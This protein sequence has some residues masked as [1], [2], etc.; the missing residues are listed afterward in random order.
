MSF[1]NIQTAEQLKD[2]IH[3]IHDFIRNSGAGYGMS[4]L[5]IFNVFYSLRIIKGKCKSFNLD[6]NSFEW[7]KLIDDEYNPIEV[8][9]S[10]I[11]NLLREYSSKGT[12]ND[13]MRLKIENGRINTLYDEFEKYINPSQLELFKDK[14]DAINDD[15]EKYVKER[16]PTEETK[17]MAFY[18]YHQ[19]PIT[20]KSE[21]YREIYKLVDN[22]PMQTIN[23]KDIGDITNKFDIKGKVYE[24]FIGR[25][26]SAISEMG[27]YFTDRY[28]TNFTFEFIDLQLD[29]NGNVPSM[30]DPFGGSGG[31]TI[32]Y[33]KMLSD[34]FNI[35]WSK[36]DNYKQVYHYDMSEDVVK[37]AGVEYFTLT[38][39]FPIR[40]SQFK[41]TNTFTEDFT[42]KFRNVISNP[43]YGGDKNKSSVDKE[44]NT[45][46]IKTNKDIIGHIEATFKKLVS[47]EVM[48]K[49]KSTS[50][51]GYVYDYKKILIEINGLEKNSN[52]FDNTAIRLFKNFCSKYEIAIDNINLFKQC[53]FLDNKDNIELDID[54][55]DDF[56][57]VLATMYKQIT[58]LTKENNKEDITQTDKQV[59]LKTCSKFIA[60][61]AVE[62]VN[63]D[64]I[65]SRK[66]TIEE[67]NKEL[68]HNTGNKIKTDNLNRL[69]KSYKKE[70]IKYTL[71]NKFKETYF[72][73]KESCSLILLMNLLEENGTCVG[74][75]KEGVFFD[76]KYSILRGFIIHNYNIT[77]IISIP[78][79]AFENT[80][81][82]TSIIVFHKNGPTAKINFWILDVE[83]SQNVLITCNKSSGNQIK[84]LKE[85]IKSVNKKYLCSASLKQLCKIKTSYNKNN[86][87]SFELSYSLDFK[88][89]IAYT[90]CCPPGFADDTLNNHLKFKP[91][92]KRQA[93]FAD[94]NGQYTFYTSSDKIKKCTELDYKDDDLKLI[95]G[96]GGNG[97]LFIDTNFSCSGDN[98]VC[99]IDNKLMTQYV[100]FYIKNNWNEFIFRM[101]NGSTIGHIGVEKLKTFKIP[102]PQDINK[103]QPQLDTLYELHLRIS[104]MTQDIPDK[105]KHICGLIKRLTDEGKKG[106]DY[107]QDKLG[108]LCEINY[109]TR[110]TKNNNT[111]GEFPVYGG[112]DIAFYTNKYN[113][114]NITC[115]IGRFG[116]GQKCVRIING[117]FWL[118]D[119]GLSIKYIKN[120]NNIE[121]Y[122]WYYLMLY[123]DNIYNNMTT[124]SIQRA[125]NMDIFNKFDIKVLKPHI[126]AQHNMQQ[127][128]DEV[129]GMKTQ[130]ETLKQS[131]KSAT[132]ELFK[133]FTEEHKI[134]I[135]CESA[136]DASQDIDTA[137][138]APDEEHVE[139]SSNASKKVAVKKTVARKKKQTIAIDDTEEQPETKVKVVA[140]R[141]KN[142]VK[143]KTMD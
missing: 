141:K 61:Y 93:S 83:K 2:Y 43:P 53:F 73:D 48:A 4:A 86:E 42:R 44:K 126:M 15:F 39:Y 69:L 50:K 67:I 19:I 41:C 45:I 26:K 65:T 12:D 134:T 54:N 114:D 1:N 25:D 82:K 95:F 71:T 9:V 20:T 17:N 37:N 97:S 11:V 6:E 79:K 138:N 64:V 137:S 100:Y 30:I 21:F 92:S 119:N 99:N 10:R 94:E 8:K 139:T 28:I 121:K 70:P 27:A 90:V 36:N 96:T 29:E 59:N 49:M 85:Q 78:D 80:T 125:L 110:I 108:K 33:T 135:S 116:L 23:K 52:A 51:A 129:D 56:F 102:I 68:L 31:F 63:N 74:L 40:E 7:D 35:D 115:I 112:G 84:Y 128:F 5:K 127:L 46:I 124:V 18:I 87:P 3:S 136:P 117:K 62:I 38:G 66:I 13:F 105:E 16:S 103:L 123:Q 143:T 57:I 89:Y 24:Y 140:A 34:N 109:G 120:N 132:S 122:I 111:N 77:D 14:L 107:D 118:H 72:K 81:T 133:D 106:V 131:Y 47:Q 98:I 113:R 60:N 130:L 142:P 88:N 91:K 58:E 76:T 101:F 22:I 104:T 32:Q 55:I 75:L